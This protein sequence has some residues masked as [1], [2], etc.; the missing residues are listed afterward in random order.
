MAV[1]SVVV[2]LWKLNVA[3]LHA[4]GNQVVTVRVGTSLISQA[5]VSGLAK[6]SLYQ[7]F[8]F[9]VALCALCAGWRGWVGWVGVQISLCIERWLSVFSEHVFPFAWHKLF[10]TG[11]VAPRSTSSRWSI[12]RIT[13]ET[14]SI[15][16]IA[17]NRVNPCQI[18]P[19]PSTP[20]MRLCNA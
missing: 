2:A 15:S 13:L 4:S 20:C 19:S 3:I 9:E 7:V 5:Q 11:Q 14:T 10:S 6:C 17:I 12:I 18:S 8:G 16:A 1:I